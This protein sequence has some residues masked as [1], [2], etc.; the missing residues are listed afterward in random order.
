MDPRRH[1]PLNATKTQCWLCKKSRYRHIVLPKEVWI[2]DFPHMECLYCGAYFPK[3]DHHTHT[4]KCRSG[5]KKD[6]YSRGHYVA[7]N[8]KE[9]PF[10][11]NTD[12]QF[13]RSSHFED[14]F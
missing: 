1:K 4:V 9:C 2:S 3:M 14:H 10:A 11:K 7:L 5:A 13:I 8:Y 6:K 12:L